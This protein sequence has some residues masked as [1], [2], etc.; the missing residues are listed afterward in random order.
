VRYR[1]L[2]RLPHNYLVKR[3]AFRRRLLQA[4]KLASDAVNGRATLH[5]FS[6]SKLLEGSWI[7]NGV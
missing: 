4:F 2:R 7:E 5:M 3:T 1:S 6:G